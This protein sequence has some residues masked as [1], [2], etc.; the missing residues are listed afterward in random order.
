LSGYNVTFDSLFTGSLCGQ[1]PY[2]SVWT[3]L[4]AMRDKNGHLDVTPQYICSVTGIPM[5]VLL[6]CIAKFT[7]PDPASRTITE[8]GRRM[9]L[10]DPNRPWGWVIIN[11]HVYKERARLIS[12][13]HKEVESG[14]NASRMED[15]R[16]PPETAG[17]PLSESEAKSEADKET[18]VALSPNISGTT[19]ESKPRGHSR[20]CQLP[21]DFALD[22]DLSAYATS[23]LPGVRLPDLLEEF[24]QHHRANGTTMK[25]WRA[26]W[27][28]WVSKAVRYGYPGQQRG[29]PQ[30]SQPARR[31]KEFGT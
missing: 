10:I 29:K 1:W 8:D 13:N 22:E 16:R 20:V 3:T 19:A 5:D 24:R 2:L 26:A 4:L 14:K 9:R 30:Q 18:R 7:A 11:H 31:P 15:R 17:D 27:R 12:K 21:E 23:R 6:D 28:T 25:D